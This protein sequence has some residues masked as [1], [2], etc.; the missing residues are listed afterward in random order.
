MRV[1]GARV[2]TIVAILLAFV[3]MVAFYVEHT[4]LDEAGF[5]TISRNLI[6]S[7]TIRTQ[8]ANTAVDKLYENVDVEAVIAERLPPHRK[9]WPRPWRASRAPAPI[10]PRRRRS[11]GLVCKRH[12]WR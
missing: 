5:K 1:I 7:D 4:A 11:N 3:G 6:Q 9:A 2:L 12:G 10:R 8:V